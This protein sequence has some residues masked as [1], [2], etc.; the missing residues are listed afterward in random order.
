M[1]KGAKSDGNTVNAFLGKSTKFNGT[2]I[3]DGLVRIDGEFEGDVKSSD[4][5]VVAESG[6]VKANIEAGTVKIS[7]VFEGN[8]VAKNKVEL[9]KPARVTGTI[10]TPSLIVE[11]G[12]IFNGSCEMGRDIKK[13]EIKKVE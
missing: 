10:K 1:I 5:F 6:K 8:I 4:T 3:F 12:V 7:G 2:L 13:A 11:D 9:Y